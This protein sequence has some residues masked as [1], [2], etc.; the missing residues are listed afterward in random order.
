MLKLMKYE[1]RKLRTALLILLA[2]LAGL[3]IGFIAG[4]AL[5]KSVLMGVCLGLITMLAFG[6]YCFILVSGVTS[7]S[8]ELSTRTGYLIF[9][10]PVGPL[11]VVLSKLLFTGLAALVSTALFGLTAYLDFRYLINRLD[12]D[13]ETLQQIN[14]MLRFG[15]NSGAD[16][17]QIARMAGYAVLMV[18]IEVLLTM[19][20]A[21]LAITL[22]ATWLQNRKGFLRTVISLALFGLLTWGCG[23]IAEK[24]LYSRVDIN[25]TFQ[26]FTGT[27]GWSLLLN[28]AFC[29]VFIAASAWLL[30]RKVNL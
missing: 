25:A 16:L 15:L 20:T 2:V 21:Y 12:I 29:A 23:W 5:N 19:C 11:G 22:S 30:D 13:P 28:G 8:R 14:F 26:Q 24:L 17:F 4:Q 18:L 1:F 10:T 7:Y 3:E 27:L 6:V 9:M